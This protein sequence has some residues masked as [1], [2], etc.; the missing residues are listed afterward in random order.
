VAAR[1]KGLHLDAFG[2]SKASAHR[3]FHVH[4][5]AREKYGIDRPL[6]ALSGNVVLADLQATRQLASEM[7]RHRDLARRPDAVVRAGDINAMG[8]IDEI[9]HYVVELYRDEYGSEVVAEALDGLRE[10]FGEQRVDSCL[11]AFATEF[12]PSSVYAQ[13]QELDD[14]LNSDIDGRSGRE[15]LL[16][17]M[18]M[19]WL[20][21]AN[22]AFGAFSEL[23]DDAGLEERTGYREL[24]S[25]LSGFFESQPAFGPDAQ[26]LVEMLRTPAELFPDSLDRQ[27]AYMRERWGN[28]L[29][30]Y[31]FRLL[32]GLDVLKE[33]AKTGFA[34]PGPSRV[35]RYEGADPDRFSPDRDWMPHVVIIAKSTLVWLDQ[36]ARA[37]R[38]DISRLDQIPDEEL[39]R[40][41][42]WGFT[43]LWLIGLWE[44][45]AASKQI[46]NTMGN[47]D[48]EASAYA[49]REYEIA[50]D[51]GGW[52]A[53]AD[54]RR[55]CEQRGIRLASDMVP[56][57]TGIDGRWVIE[58]PDW[59]I[60]VPHP[61]FPSYTY[62][63]ENLSGVPGIGIYLEDHYYTRSDAAV[64]FKRADF[65]AHD[66]RYIYHGNDGTSMP[67]NDTAQLDFT[68][69]EVREAVI[70]TILHVARSFS[71]I[72]FDA[73]M[74][75]AKRHIQRLWFPEPGSGGDIPSR[76]E[77]GMS[78][79]AFDAAIPRR[80]IRCSS[81]RRSG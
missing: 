49:L 21:N 33:E 16:E 64:V 76:A 55:R 72:R 5:D 56:N 12:P 80:P 58:H 66:E 77:H 74:T 3:E 1:R 43:G 38:R 51:L 34:G 79:E 23:F 53:L 26:P 40:L 47:P 29:G 30:A 24:I 67:W 63:G 48:A 14:F 57:H 54:L 7:N 18:L 9:L 60:Q 78:A 50:D 65:A 6:Y 37:Y 44:R 73:A 31:L 8:L 25:E 70:Q 17:E 19:L 4:R 45:S 35:Y 32:R 75:L 10:R 13:E 41:A 52:D 62:S 46:K 71:I 69:P 20:E 39:D 59:F 68:K 11:R 15:V 28:L 42:S 36:L 27:L 81:P 22:P 2:V 61:P